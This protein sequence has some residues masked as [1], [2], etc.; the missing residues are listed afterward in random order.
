MHWGGLKNKFLK[1]NP[2]YGEFALSLSTV[3]VIGFPEN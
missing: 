1:I 2:E 3:K